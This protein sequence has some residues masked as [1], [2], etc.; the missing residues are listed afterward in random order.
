MIVCID[1]IGAFF[2]G[3]FRFLVQKGIS[4]LKM[5]LEARRIKCYLKQN[6]GRLNS[7][8]SNSITIQFRRQNEPLTVKG[9]P[10]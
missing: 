8:I 10:L 4:S 1:E 5:N 9:N 3:I 6:L 2:C 7:K